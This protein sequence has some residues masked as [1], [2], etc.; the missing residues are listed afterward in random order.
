MDKAYAGDIIGV[1]NHGQLQIG[2]VLTEG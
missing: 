2:D 1:H